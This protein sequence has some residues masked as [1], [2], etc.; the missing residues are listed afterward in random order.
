MA[1]KSTRWIVAAGVLVLVALGGWAT[2]RY[3]TEP[4]RMLSRAID[5]VRG[6]RLPAGF[7]SGNGR[8]EAT[9]YDIA[10]KRSGRLAAVLVA[11]GATVEPGQVLARMDTQDLEADLREAEAQAVQA[12][13]DKRRALA[14]VAQRQS[15]LQSTVAAIAQREAD[16]A[17]PMPPLPSARATSRAP[18]PPLRSG[19]APS[20]VRPPPSRS[21]RA[22][23]SWRRRSWN[24]PRRSSPDS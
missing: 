6:P 24:A 21:A 16:P 20:A 7:A 5:Y 4:G 14:G 19:T 3:L 2:W 8:I 17:G 1:A 12:R 11:E 10:S 15:D 22:S 18:T 23:S 13:E 9:E